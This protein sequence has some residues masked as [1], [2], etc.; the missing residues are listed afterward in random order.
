ME[1]I[2]L[3]ISS[4]AVFSKVG[5]PAITEI[6]F[7]K[8][9][10]PKTSLWKSI[11]SWII[12]ITLTYVV[13]FIG[14]YYGIGFMVDYVVWWAPLIYGSVAAGLS[15]FS[16]MNIPWVKQFILNLLGKMPKE[17]QKNEE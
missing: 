16:W 14:K 1:E 7:T 5:L 6:I 12:P 2:I 15:N 3:W 8:I 10:E 4:F 17:K 13:W 11:W 9:K